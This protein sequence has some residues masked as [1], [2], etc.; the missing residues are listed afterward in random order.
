ME[1]MLDLLTRISTLYN[2]PQW[3]VNTGAITIFIIL[4]AF[5]FVARKLMEPKHRKFKEL[6]MYNVVWRW[7]YKKDEIVGL[8]CHCPQCHGMLMCDDENCR[9]TEELQD[10]ITFFVCHECGGH[11]QGRVVGGD[12]RYAISLVKREALRQIR[13]GD[14]VATMKLAKEL[15]DTLASFEAKLQDI[16]AD[17][18]L[19]KSTPI[20]IVEEALE[21]EIEVIVEDKE[22]AKIEVEKEKAEVP[23]GV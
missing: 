20:E 3:A 21:S 8:W 22:V 1:K 13:T 16:E 11:E 12:R 7:K 4:V 18:E 10:K 23:H 17:S 9:A 15:K 2:I 14:Y 19:A 5:P 6:P